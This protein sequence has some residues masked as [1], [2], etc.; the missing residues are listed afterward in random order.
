[1]PGRRLHTAAMAQAMRLVVEAGAQRGWALQARCTGLWLSAQHIGQ[2]PLPAWR[3]DAA[4]ALLR[5]GLLSLPDV[6][7]SIAQV[8]PWHGSTCCRHL[9]GLPLTWPWQSLCCLST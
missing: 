9:A 5:R 4:D 1:M 7:S 6:D 8:S 3:S 2:E